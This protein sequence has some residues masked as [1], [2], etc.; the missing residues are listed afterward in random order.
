M[1]R[2]NVPYDCG[3][4]YCRSAR[5]HEAVFGPGANAPAY[6]STEASSIPSPLNVRLENSSRFRGLPLY[7]SL[8]SYGNQGYTEVVQRNITYAR[9]IEAWLQE[10]EDYDVLTPSPQEGFKVLN[11]VLFAPSK[12][13][14]VLQ[15]RDAE[16]GGHKMTT[17]LN[18]SGEMYVTG[19]KWKGRSAARLAVSN[20]LTA[21]HDRDFELVTRRLQSI[22]KPESS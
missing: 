11:I 13:C 7:S 21:Q 8:V 16:T 12:R 9:R 15:F 18:A 4:F 20:Y 6:L 10:N 19:T 5:I 17:A 2:L 3:I 1:C 22:M 14:P